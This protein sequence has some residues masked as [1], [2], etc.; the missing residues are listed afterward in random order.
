ML[1]K[2]KEACQILMEETFLLCG[3]LEMQQQATT[4]DQVKQPPESQKPL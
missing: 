2:A 4:S 1:W 3:L